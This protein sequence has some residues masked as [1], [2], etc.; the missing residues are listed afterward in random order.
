MLMKG[1]YDEILLKW[2]LV[3]KTSEIVM[4]SLSLSLSHV[5]EGF[6][7]FLSKL[8]RKGCVCVCVC[9]W[10]W[11]WWY[12]WVVTPKRREVGGRKVTIQTCR[13]TQHHLPHGDQGSFFID[14]LM[15][16]LSLSLSL[17][18]TPSTRPLS[19]TTPLNSLTPT[20]R[21]VSLFLLGVFFF[22]FSLPFSLDFF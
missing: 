1:D 15:N 5:L 2:E 20:R 13:T 14:S 18:L 8:L 6:L 9:V 19:I 4:T 12:S 21:F 10:W 16:P 22:F 11:W 3:G 7:S 17:S